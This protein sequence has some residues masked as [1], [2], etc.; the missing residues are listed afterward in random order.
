M[1]LRFAIRTHKENKR[2]MSALRLVGER[3]SLAIGT[4]LLKKA[5]NRLLTRAAQNRAY[6]FTKTYGAATV[7]ERP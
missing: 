6:M 1:G 7:R 2:P 5:K 3:F 4:G